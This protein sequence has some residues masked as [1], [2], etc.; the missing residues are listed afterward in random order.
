M[1]N[2]AVNS[3]ISDVN[4]VKHWIIHLSLTE[5]PKSALRQP[6]PPPSL[7]CI[8]R[9]LLIHGWCKAFYRPKTE[10]SLSASVAAL[11]S[12][13][14]SIEQSPG[15]PVKSSFIKA[16]SIVHKGPLTQGYHQQ[17]ANSTSHHCRNFDLS[18][19]PKSHQTGLSTIQI[20]YRSLSSTDG[21]WI[22]AANWI[23]PWISVC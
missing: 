8:W 4:N 7:L 11:L 19:L 22:V 16:R 3:N 13:L 15:L 14:A 9:I 18:G 21:N 17:L 6:T 10:W 12:L 5:N 1:L 2:N 23:S 20:S